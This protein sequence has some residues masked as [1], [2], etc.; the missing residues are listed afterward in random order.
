MINHQRLDPIVDYSQDTKPLRTFFG[1]PE[2]VKFCSSCVISNQRP[3]STVEFSHTAN[4]KKKTIQFDPF[5]ICDACRM[6]EKKRTEVDWDKREAELRELCDRYRSKDGSFDCIVPGSGGKDSFMQ[7]HLLK[8]KYGMN[9]LTVTWAPHLYT[10]WGRENFDSWLNAGF[11]NYLVTPNPRIH[12]LLT[13]LAIEK[14]L[15]PFQPFILGQKSIGPK[16]AWLMDIPLVFFGEN[17]A[18][19]GNPLDEN[20]SSQRGKEFHSSSSSETFLGGV[21]IDELESD[22]GVSRGELKPYLPMD[23]NQAVKKNVEVHYLGYYLQWHPQGAYY[24]SV[25]NGGFRA[26]PERTPGT[27]SKYNSID[28]K[29]DD[30]HY[31]TTFIKFGIG[32]A[33]YDA[34]QEIRNGEI[35]REEGVALVKKFDGEYPDRFESEIFQYL[36]LPESQFPRASQMFDK[37]I[38]TRESFLSTCDAFRSPHLWAFDSKSNAWKLRHT[39]WS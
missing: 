29:I 37:P 32:R 19:Y 23:L 13:R 5:D 1:L 34:S 15:H 17:E 25:E 22:F 30:F 6:A 26:A 36:S 8:T 21:S 27:Y 7:S 3:N 4:S 9:P 16:L 11:D 2:R 14:L 35:T 24:Y 18:E 38:M 31:F 12:R 20:F 39:V 33:S 28:D 10:T